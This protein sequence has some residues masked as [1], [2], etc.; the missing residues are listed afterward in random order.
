MMSRTVKSD[1]EVALIRHGVQLCEV[2]GWA[3]IAA[4]KDGRTEVEVANACNVAIAQGLRER[5][6]DIEYDDLNNKCLFQTG[7]YRSRVGHTMNAHRVIQR[8]EMLSNNPYCIRD[9]LE[10]MRTNN[11]A[12]YDLKWVKPAPLIERRF[13]FEVKE[14]MRHTGEVWKVLDEAGARGLAREIRAAG[15]KAVAVCFLHA[16]AKALRSFA[17]NSIDT[18]SVSIPSRPA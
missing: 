13:R 17:L 6:P 5:F 16:Y 9:I 10:I 11:P 14:R 8:G 7:P 18:V 1:E 12:M 3:A 15:I 2:G 4:L